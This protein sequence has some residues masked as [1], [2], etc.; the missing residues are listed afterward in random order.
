VYRLLTCGSW[1]NLHRSQ[2]EEERKQ[3][4]LSNFKLFIQSRFLSGSIARK[5]H[6]PSALARGI[7]GLNPFGFVRPRPDQLA[8]FKARATTRGACSWKTNIGERKLFAR[9]AAFCSNFLLMGIKV[10]LQGSWGLLRK[11]FVV[12]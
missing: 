11:T 1:A 9:F 8:V 12:S 5:S 7:F 4:V 10:T 2:T 3:S 6:E